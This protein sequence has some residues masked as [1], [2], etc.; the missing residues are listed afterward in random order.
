MTSGA[1][2]SNIHGNQ[3]PTDNKSDALAAVKTTFLE[4]YDHEGN[5]WVTM[6]VE[7][8]GAQPYYVDFDSISQIESCMWQ[9][10]QYLKRRAL[11]AKDNRSNDPAGSPYG[12][13]A[14]REPGHAA[15][16]PAPYGS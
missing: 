6:K 8:Q 9:M 7:I 3:Q 11:F 15:E 16:P 12:Y 14:E 4:T 13:D 5:V 10:Q 1:Y 2:D